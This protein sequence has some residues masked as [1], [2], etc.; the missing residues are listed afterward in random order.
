MSGQDLFNE[1]QEVQR[2]LETSLKKLFKNG[3]NLSEC[4]KSYRIA[5]A[6]KQLELTAQGYK[7]TIVSDLSRGDSEVAQLKL[8]RDIAEVEYKTCMEAINV[9]KIESRSL[10]NQIDRE[11]S[12]K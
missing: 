9:R 1:L 4:E 10:E 11:W 7:V 2:K 8:L 3:V 12:R 6:K 5:L